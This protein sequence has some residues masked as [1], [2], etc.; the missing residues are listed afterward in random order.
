MANTIDI[1]TRQLA[2]NSHIVNPSTASYDSVVVGG[3]GGSALAALATRWLG[4]SK[5][6][7]VHRDYDVPTRLPERA[8]YV[9]VSHSGNTEE[10]LSFAHAVLKQKLLLAVVASGGKLLELAKEHALSCVEV[11]SDFVP[12]DSTFYHLRALEVLLG[13]SALVGVAD[14][15]DQ[16]QIL[17]ETE[18]VASALN[19]RVPL[20]YASTQNEILAY[21]WKIILNETAKVPAFHNVFP[22]FN[23]NEMQ[24][25]DPKGPLSAQV[26]LMPVVLKDSED[27]PRIAHR[28]NVFCDI[29]TKRGSEPLVISGVTGA[30]GARLLWHWFLAREVAHM[31]AEKY[32][33]PADEVPLIEEFKK[34]L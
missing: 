24:G 2:W 30:R 7:T 13:E 16:A 11:P 5:S 18:R 14:I 12:R 3:M 17:T 8:L 29:S 28:M 34:Q 23:H 22:E 15:P 27:N 21:I 25:I 32:G 1:L 9:A 31:L 4:F 26:P 19:E 20:I 10:T 6:L 33:V